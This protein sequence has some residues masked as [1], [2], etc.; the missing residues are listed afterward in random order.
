MTLGRLKDIHN[1]RHPTGDK[2]AGA[3]KANHSPFLGW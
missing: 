3:Q 2:Q 1:Q